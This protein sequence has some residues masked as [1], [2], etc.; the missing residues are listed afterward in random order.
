MLIFRYTYLLVYTIRL[1]T[2][3][4][5][6]IK[7]VYVYIFVFRSDCKK[8]NVRVV[9]SLFFC[10]HVIYKNYHYIRK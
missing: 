4:G 2:L 5:I 7:N 3:L 6:C 10:R 9:S 1:Q 8:K